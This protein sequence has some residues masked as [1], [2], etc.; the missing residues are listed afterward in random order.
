M[1]SNWVDYLQALSIADRNQTKKTS[2]QVY[3][4]YI[5]TTASQYYRE[6]LEKFNPD[7]ASQI[8]EFKEGNLLFEIMQ[9]KIW[10]VAS[11]DSAGLRYFYDHLTDKNH[12]RW[13][14]SVQALILTA[15]S[16]SMAALAIATLKQEPLEWRKLLDLN[17][18][19][20]FG[21]S[22]RYEISQLPIVSGQTL[23]P[24][25]IT[26]AIKNE[27]DN[28]QTF[29]YIFSVVKD[30]SVRSFEEAKGAIINDY[31]NYLEENWIRSLKKEYPVII[32]DSVLNQL[33]REK[34]RK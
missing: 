8:R 3:Q 23:L 34:A 18:G 31:Q 9:R 13:Q 19:S 29:C 10:D 27:T 25:T 7:F 32:N 24:N 12:Y 22:S 5:E 20:L 28:S 6:N 21:D 11:Q 4:Q 17:N 30:N 26:K 15:N 2:A 33:I 14:S 1:F 16:D